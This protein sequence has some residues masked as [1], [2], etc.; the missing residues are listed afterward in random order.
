MANQNSVNQVI[1]VGRLARDVVSKTSKRGKSLREHAQFTVVTNEIYRDFKQNQ[2][3]NRTEFHTVVAWGT[4]A[5][6]I[7]NY[8][9][10]GMILCVLGK[11]R[12]TQYEKEGKTVYSTQ[13]A[14]DEMTYLGAKGDRVIPEPYT[15]VKSEADNAEEWRE[16]QL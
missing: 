16:E 5:K 1:L 6:F 7:G 15:K 4:A 14:V 9:K 13:V 8:G 11:L 2:T 12:H 10:K 3:I